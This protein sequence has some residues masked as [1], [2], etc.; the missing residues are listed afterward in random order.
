MRRSQ[1]GCW[2]EERMSWKTQFEIFYFLSD[3]SRPT[4][5][6][7]VLLASQPSQLTTDKRTDRVYLRLRMLLLVW[8]SSGQYIN[9]SFRRIPG[10]VPTVVTGVCKR[11]LTCRLSSIMTTVHVKSGAG[12]APE[13]WCIPNTHHTMDSGKRNTGTMNQTW[14]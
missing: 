5:K 1:F 9:L 3:H 6:R 10:S 13:K 4:L 12:L 8:L 11:I 14:S 7:P 2:S